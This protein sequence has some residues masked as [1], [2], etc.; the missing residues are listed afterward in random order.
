MSKL[1]NPE[2]FLLLVC[3]M[4]AMTG[5]AG[6]ALPYKA[7]L[8][9]IRQ[10]LQLSTLA[11]SSYQRVDMINRY[12]DTVR[13]MSVDEISI[14]NSQQYDSIQI[15]PGFHEVRVY[16]SWDLGVQRGLAPAMVDYARTRDHVSRT[17]RFNARAGESYSVNA[18]PFFDSPS[19]NITTLSH[20]DFWVVDANG[21]EIVTQEQG[22]YIPSTN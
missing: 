14:Q 6:I 15:E 9:E 8:G 10:D 7:Y 19:R 1:E 4:M 22:R 2:R 17:L 11:G 20:V 3:V 18:Q 21:T 12:V 5:C 16:F 13:F